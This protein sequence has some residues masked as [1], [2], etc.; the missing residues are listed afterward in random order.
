MKLAD[1]LPCMRNDDNRFSLALFL[2]CR[3]GTSWSKLRKGFW[4]LC[5][6]V[7]S[8]YIRISMRISLGITDETLC[9]IM[10]LANARCA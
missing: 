8:V 10:Y 2:S 3:F 4:R 5:L 9:A 6:E 7:C 1:S